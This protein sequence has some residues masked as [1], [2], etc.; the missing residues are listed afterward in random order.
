MLDIYVNKN[1]LDQVTVQLIM[2]IYDWTRLK[3][4]D[5]WK[6]VKQILSESETEKDIKEG[7]K[8]STKKKIRKLEKR[9][10]DLET[11]VAQYQ[12]KSC[13]QLSEDIASDVKKN[14]SFKKLVGGRT[15]FEQKGK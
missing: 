15:L 12:L 6:Q 9:V 7:K 1:I 8:T 5:A 10:A 3:N 13:V 2:T 11:T 14:L 4:S